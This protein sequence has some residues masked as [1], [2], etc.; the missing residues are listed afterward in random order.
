MV[1]SNRATNFGK[2]RGSL[3]RYQM[4]IGAVVGL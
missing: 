2:V 1:V 3:M 4:L